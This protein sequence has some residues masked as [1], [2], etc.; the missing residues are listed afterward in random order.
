MK[1]TFKNASLLALALTLTSSLPLTAGNQYSF[2][3]ATTSGANATRGALATSMGFIY[4]ASPFGGTNSFGTVF[5]FDPNT[6]QY[7]VVY[8]FAGGDGGLSPTGVIRTVNGLYG[9]TSGGMNGRGTLYR[10]NLLNNAVTTL[11]QFAPGTGGSPNGP[12]LEGSDGKIYG[13]VESETATN[14]GGIYCIDANG[15]NYTLLRSFSGTGGS[16]RGK[17]VGFGGIVEGPGG[18]L[19]GA[20]P[21]GGTNDTGVFFRMSLNGF[22]YSVF[23]EWPTTGLR[24]PSNRLMVGS[25]GLFYG[26]ASEGGAANKGGIYRISSGGEYT[27]LHEFTDSTDGFLVLDDLTEGNDGYLYGC[28]FQSSN[29]LGSLFRLAKDGSSFAVLHRFTGGTT[30]GANPATPLL[31]TQ[32]GVFHGFTASA[33]A[34]NAGVAFRLATTVEKPTVKVS[35]SLRPVFRGRTL[36]LRGTAADDLGV[37]RVEYAAKSTFKPTRGTTSW[38]ARIPIKPSAKR[39]TV[40]VRAFDNDG[41]FSPVAVVRARRAK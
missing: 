39:V 41:T 14:F 8:S 25:D 37:V 3:D 2:V 29:N 6:N 34:N 11:H 18:L 33:G 9:T 13:I 26:A 23:R 22:E 24:K 16:S 36:R 4:G 40:Q 15:D 10:L 17:G 30:D 19:Y 5:R 7:T 27:E 35:G 1:D 28:A 12:L 20:T 38:N 31:E 21:R 32:S